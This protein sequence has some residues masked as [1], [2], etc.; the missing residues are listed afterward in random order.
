MR[1]AD[2]SWS[3]A[4][5]DSTFVENPFLNPSLYTISGIDVP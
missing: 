2:E 3:G 1:R 5:E 4:T